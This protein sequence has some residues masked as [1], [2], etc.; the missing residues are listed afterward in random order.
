MKMMSGDG[1]DEDIDVGT[2][3]YLQDYYLPKRRR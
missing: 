3:Y 1:D 2:Y